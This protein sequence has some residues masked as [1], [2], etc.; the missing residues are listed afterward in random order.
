[1]TC[2]LHQMYYF[3]HPKKHFRTVNPKYIESFTY[4]QHGLCVASA[5]DIVKQGHTDVDKA[6]KGH[7]TEN[8]MK[9]CRVQNYILLRETCC[10]DLQCQSNTHEH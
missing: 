7:V 9:T 3:K 2:Q 1:M 6:L 5:P 8:R 4:T 10:T